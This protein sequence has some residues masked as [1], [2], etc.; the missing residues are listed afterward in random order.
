[1]R[2]LVYYVLWTT[3]DLTGIVEFFLIF[4]SVLGSFV[5]SIGFKSSHLGIVA[6]V[7]FWEGEDGSS[8]FSAGELEAELST[9][10]ASQESALWFKPDM[11]INNNDY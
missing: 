3:E 5:V 1:M 2:N 9:Y 8:L 11:T 10:H 4:L 7:S 6:L